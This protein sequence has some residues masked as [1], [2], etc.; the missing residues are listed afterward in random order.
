MKKRLLA[1]LLSTGLIA[2]ASAGALAADFSTVP[3]MT[4]DTENAAVSQSPPAGEDP[5]IK[6]FMEDSS[7]ES[8]TAE[9]LPDNSISDE[10]SQSEG[11][12]AD[13]NDSDFTTAD[14]E[15][16]PDE[17]LFYSGSEGTEDLSEEE[18]FSDN[19]ETE[20]FGD[21]SRFL[22]SQLFPHPDILKYQSLT[23][24]LA[25]TV[26]NGLNLLMDKRFRLNRFIILL[27]SQ[28]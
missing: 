9:N 25:D 17:D 5:D 8:N 2:T 24:W 10:A 19:M 15:N 20:Y 1:L 27:H 3:E 28:R 13:D 4:G 23:F 22:N 18:G 21:E 16:I 7:A 11:T 26:R 14:S 12:S 6:A